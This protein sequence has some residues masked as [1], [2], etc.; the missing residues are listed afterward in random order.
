MK[1]LESFY[2]AWSEKDQESIS[3][4]VTFAKRKADEILSG[5]SSEVFAGMRHVVEVGCG[6]GKF[7]SEMSWR[8]GLESAIGIDT[9][10]LFVR[11]NWKCHYV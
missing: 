4:D 7:L 10:E 6:Y 1:S 9:N 2:A 3:F 11:K 8:L 5:L